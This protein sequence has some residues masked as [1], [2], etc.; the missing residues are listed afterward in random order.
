MLLNMLKFLNKRAIGTMSNTVVCAIANAIKLAPFVIVSLIVILM[1]F[2]FTSCSDVFF[3]QKEVTRIENK[4]KAEIKEKID[5][6]NKKSDEAVTLLKSTNELN[7]KSLTQNVEAEK[8]INEVSSTKNAAVKEKIIEIKEKFNQ[9]PISVTNVKI[10]E[11]AISVI[12]I[13]SIWSSYCDSTP[14]P[15]CGEK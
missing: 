15:S 12:L 14:K 2:K 1:M 11:D 9:L 13:D 8:K 7:I 10:K 3:K 4:N 5:Q 6:A